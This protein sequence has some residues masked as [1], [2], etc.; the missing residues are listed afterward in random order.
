MLK[1]YLVLFA[2]YHFKSIPPHT[3]SLCHSL[4]LGVFEPEA[5]YL[6]V[7]IGPGVQHKMYQF[8][9]YMQVDSECNHTIEETKCRC[10]Y[11][12]IE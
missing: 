3:D 8:E 12:D 9:Q 1:V 7:E 10:R 4:C 11:Y 2:V 6:V 5:G